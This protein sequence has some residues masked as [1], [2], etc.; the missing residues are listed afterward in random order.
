[1]FI[2]VP[3]YYKICSLHPSHDFCNHF[4]ILL[5]HGVAI[6]LIP[7]PYTPD[8]SHKPSYKSSLA[9]KQEIYLV[10]DAQEG[11]DFDQ[12]DVYGIG[13]A[14]DIK[15]KENHN[16]EPNK[17]KQLTSPKGD[18]A[19]HIINYLYER[20]LSKN[21]S[22]GKLIREMLSDFA[23]MHDYINTIER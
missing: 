20:L 21:P 11:I 10:V 9:L 3:S 18:S 19:F 14:Y 2:L 7:A 1:M 8:T 6:P 13:A 12:D 16:I 4:L 17:I 5:D 23:E 22:Q 15:G